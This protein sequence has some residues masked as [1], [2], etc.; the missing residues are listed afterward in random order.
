MPC[1][2]TSFLTSSP[3]V[4]YS[5]LRPSHSLALIAIRAQCATRAKTHTLSFSLSLS[6]TRTHTHTQIF[7]C[8]IPYANTGLD[9]MGIAN[10]VLRCVCTCAHVSFVCACSLLRVCV[11]VQ[12]YV[13]VYVRVSS[14]TNCST[15][16]KQIVRTYTES[17]TR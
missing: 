12:A 14:I 8:E 11:C 17:N 1:L 16:S 9:Q 6:H 2:V 5:F 4:H 10:G 7:H 15:T 3:R 13:R